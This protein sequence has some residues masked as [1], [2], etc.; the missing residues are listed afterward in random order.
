MVTAL[1]AEF[2]KLLTVRSTYVIAG[3]AYALLAFVSLYVEGYKNGPDNITGPGKGLYLAG[4][5]VQH[6]NVLSIF[7]AIVALLLVTHEYRYNTIIY[8]FTAINRRSKVLAAKIIAVLAYVLLLAV[9]GAAI[10]FIFMLLGLHLAGVHLPAQDLNI[11]TYGAKV[12]FFCE[13]WAMAAMLF[14]VLLRNQVA[15]LAV[16]FIVPNT[17]EGLLSLLLKDKTVYLPFSALSQVIAPP[18]IPGAIARHINETGSLSPVHGALLFLGYIVGAW[19]VA[20]ILFVKRDA[21]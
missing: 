13:G 12:V 5:V 2:R 11:W 16:L 7:G 9:V 10:G 1:K 15:A 3:I 20:W 8:A 17:V 14:A 6:A 4:T 19:I 21:F 18:T